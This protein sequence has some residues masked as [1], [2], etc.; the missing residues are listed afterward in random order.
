MALHSWGWSQGSGPRT[1]SGS[2]HTGNPQRGGEKSG[3]RSATSL[4]PRWVAQRQRG[5][6]RT[7]GAPALTAD[8][9]PKRPV[10]ASNRP[11]LTSGS[12]T[13]RNGVSAATTTHFGRGARIFKHERNPSVCPPPTSHMQSDPRVGATPPKGCTRPPGT[14]QVVSRSGA[15][16]PPAGPRWSGHVGPARP[17]L[18]RTRVRG[19]LWNG[20]FYQA[21]CVG[22]APPRLHLDLH[23]AAASSRG[24]HHVGLAALVALRVWPLL[25]RSL[26]AVHDDAGQGPLTC[27][28][29]RGREGHR[30]PSSGGQLPSLPLP[31]ALVDMV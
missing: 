13:A 30:G 27:G 29:G 18:F 12:L 7:R 11:A 16:R 6:A 26:D 9:Y 23:W 3:I 28:M 1:G 31:P 8:P 17:P 19:G 15:V 20:P 21:A 25:I 4:R 14:I 5:V 22:L 2:R 24:C 10:A